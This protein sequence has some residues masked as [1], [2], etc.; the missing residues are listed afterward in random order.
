MGFSGRPLRPS[1]ADHVLY[2][3]LRRVVVASRHSCPLLSSPSSLHALP[4]LHNLSTQ[5]L[6]VL[7][8]GC[9]FR[10][11]GR[12]HRVRGGV[13]LAVEK[14]ARAGN[15]HALQKPLTSQPGRSFCSR[16]GPCPSCE[17]R[18]AR[19]SPHVPVL[20]HV[21]SGTWPDF[22]ARGPSRWDVPRFASRLLFSPRT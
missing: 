12:I 2:L 9:T 7:S 18:P 22:G 4:W 3:L 5:F 19:E 11:A 16:I 8:C 14:D 17:R 10:V 6:G 1:P 21:F 20:E 13:A 15:Q